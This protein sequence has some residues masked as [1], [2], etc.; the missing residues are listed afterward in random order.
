M[1]MESLLCTKKPSNIGSSAF[2]VEFKG[3]KSSQDLYAWINS[4]A[5]TKTS[6]ASTVHRSKPFKSASG[7]ILS[8]SWNQAH[9]EELKTTNA[10]AGTAPNARR[11]DRPN[12]ALP[13][14]AALWKAAYHDPAA[15]PPAL[16]IL[17]HNATIMNWSLAIVKDYQELSTNC[18]SNNKL[19]IHQ[20]SN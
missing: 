2:H 9:M 14:M 20:S 18:S 4:Y 7:L 3:R 19:P 12:S 6:K 17:Q 11:P 10:T 15:T 1:F 13:P 16:P 5:H 8:L